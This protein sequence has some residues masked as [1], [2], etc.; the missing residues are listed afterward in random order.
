MHPDQPSPPELSGSPHRTGRRPFICT[1]TRDGHEIHNI[2]VSDT[3]HGAASSLAKTGM[4]PQ[5][6]TIVVTVST[7]DRPHFEVNSRFETLV[8]RVRSNDDSLTRQSLS[9]T[10]EPQPELFAP[11]LAAEQWGT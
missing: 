8:C 6:A 1:Y 4:V 10:P 3:P 5:G 11:M 9:R 7:S 2:Q